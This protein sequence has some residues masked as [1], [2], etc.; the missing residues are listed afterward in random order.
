MQNLGKNDKTYEYLC[1][2]KR[3]EI[4]QELKNRIQKVKEL[5]EKVKYLK[6]LVHQYGHF[7][8]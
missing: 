4:K 7:S 5:E 8:K 2:L 1:L 6:E 3:D